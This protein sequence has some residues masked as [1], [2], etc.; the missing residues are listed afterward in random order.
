MG[1]LSSKDFH[2]RNFVGEAEA[3]HLIERSFCLRKV[4]TR[5]EREHL[6]KGFDCE[7]R[8]SVWPEY[9]ETLRLKDRSVKIGRRN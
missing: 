1:A 6:E 2:S 7:L 8:E 9:S 4:N 3:R 5:E